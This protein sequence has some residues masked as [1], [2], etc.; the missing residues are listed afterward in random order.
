MI[1]AK[2]YQ[3]ISPKMQN[4]GPVPNNCFLHIPC[5]EF[6][7][8]SINQIVRFQFQKYN[9]FPAS[10]G[11]TSPLRHPLWPMR[12]GAQLALTGHQVIPQY[13]GRIYAPEKKQKQKQKQTKQ[14]KTKQKKN[15]YLRM[16]TKHGKGGLQFEI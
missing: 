10:E 14:N 3:K 4:F 13:Q 1:L 2:F 5:S 7:P 8:R 15:H 11:D 12:E 9:I 16:K 6:A